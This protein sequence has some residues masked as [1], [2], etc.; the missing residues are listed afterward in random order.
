[1]VRPFPHSPSLS[2]SLSTSSSP[3]HCRLPLLRQSNKPTHWTQRKTGVIGVG[4][5]LTL[6]EQ[7]ILAP[8]T[9]RLFLEPLQHV[10]ADLLVLT[11]LQ[12]GLGST[13]QPQARTEPQF[14]EFV[15]FSPFPPPISPLLPLFLL[16]PLTNSL[17]YLVLK[18]VI[19]DSQGQSEGTE[20]EMEKAMQ[21]VTAGNVPLPSEPTD[22]NAT[23]SLFGA[24]APAAS[25]SVQPITTAQLQSSTN[26]IAAV[27]HT[28]PS[29]PTAEQALTIGGQ[30]SS[31]QA[32]VSGLEEVPMEGV[33][34]TGGEV[35]QEERSLAQ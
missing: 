15:S 2:P 14:Q 30:E 31:V 35:K 5:T 19:D 8:V 27:H 4:S 6:A 12:E 7:Q 23:I 24:P 3:R 9:V 10:C 20:E 32:A 18:W 16:T 33:I 26:P 34:G 25:A 28:N 21:E 22:P 17:L 29:K 13:K 11:A 1:M